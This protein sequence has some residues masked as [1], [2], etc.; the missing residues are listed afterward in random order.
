MHSK[1]ETFEIIFQ[2]SEKT[3]IKRTKVI[4]FLSN[5]TSSPI[6]RTKYVT[7]LIKL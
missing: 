5:F 2:N 4:N 6:L 3:Y 7:D 1:S